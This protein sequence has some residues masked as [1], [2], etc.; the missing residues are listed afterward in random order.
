MIVE[1]PGNESICIMQNDLLAE[2]EA[3]RLY[4]G[5]GLNTTD[6]M[7]CRVVKKPSLNGVMYSEF[8]LLNEL[9]AMSDSLEEA[10]IVAQGDD[11][12]KIHYDW[13]FPVCEQSFSSKQLD[14]RKINVLNMQGA[15]LDDFVPLVKLKSNIKVDAKSAAWILGRFLKLQSFLDEEGNYHS[16]DFNPDMVLVAPKSHHVVYIGW[17]DDLLLG[18]DR[19]RNRVELISRLNLDRMFYTIET[20]VEPNDTPGEE[21]FLAWLKSAN[22][23]FS[24]GLRAHMAYYDFLN[25]LWG[26]GYYPFTFK[27][28]GTWKSVDKLV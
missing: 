22:G 19:S 17:F 15:P 28:N 3:Y 11:G 6:A 14:G 7:L 20:W 8:M 5:R 21:E 16:L 9:A 2:T 12:R 25:E 4:L 13:L 23:R 24:N 1:R 18:G 10:R 26:S 27:E